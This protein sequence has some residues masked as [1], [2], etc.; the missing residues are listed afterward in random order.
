MVTRD[1][2]ND[3]PGIPA[4]VVDSIGAGDCFTAALTYFSL[5]G[6]PLPTLAEAANRWGAWA[7]SQRGGMPLLD[8]ACPPDLETATEPS[9]T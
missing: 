6:R 3:H 7:A 5:Q 2:V 8:A 1:A 4:H 9:A